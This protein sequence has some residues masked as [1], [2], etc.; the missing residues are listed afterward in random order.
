MV[1]CNSDMALRGRMGGYV[2]AARYSPQELTS[3][4]RNG[5]MQRFLDEADP[6]KKLPD[7]ERWRRANLLLKAHMAK[8]AR[9]SA[10]ARQKGNGK[11]KNGWGPIP[12]TDWEAVERTDRLIRHKPRGEAALIQDIHG[13]SR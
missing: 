6:H 13:G 2:K 7:E 8:L 3:A 4:A 9:A 11:R 1:I 10:L 5:F 12:T